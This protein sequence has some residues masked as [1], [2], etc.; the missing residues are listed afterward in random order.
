[1]AAKHKLFVWIRV[2]D[3]DGYHRFN[4]MCDAGA[5]VSDHV[6]GGSGKPTIKPIF[7]RMGVQIGPDYFTGQNYVSLFW[8][9]GGSQHARRFSVKDLAEFRRGFR[10]HYSPE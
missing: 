7:S 8:G 6:F 5:E 3:G 1:M 10:A 4:S 9:D 2:G